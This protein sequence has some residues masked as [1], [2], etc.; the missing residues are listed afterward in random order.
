[1]GIYQELLYDA[2]TQNIKFY[3]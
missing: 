1:L 3:S 2:R